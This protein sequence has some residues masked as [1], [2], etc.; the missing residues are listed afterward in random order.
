MWVK[1]FQNVCTYLCLVAEVYDGYFK[2]DF[3]V[4]DTNVYINL[5]L[6]TD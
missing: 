3:S 6:V 4:L 1:G 2:I 5:L